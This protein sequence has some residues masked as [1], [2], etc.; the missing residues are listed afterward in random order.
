M[1]AGPRVSRGGSMRARWCVG[2]LAVLG[3][4][5]EAW[6]QSVELPSVLVTAEPEPPKNKA[7]KKTKKSTGEKG[8]VAP[9]PG[10]F[11][12]TVDGAKTDDE[13][14]RVEQANPQVIIDRERF[15]AHPSGPRAN[16]AIKRLPGV[17]VSGGID[18]AKDIRIRGLDKEFSRVA[19]DGVQLP[20]SGE[21]R[22]LQINRVPS[23]A[24]ESLTLVRT[25]TADLEHDGIA[26]R[27]EI[28][29]RDIPKV[30]TTETDAAVG[31]IDGV[32]DFAGHFQA[33]TGGRVGNVGLMVYGSVVEEPR[34]KSKDKFNA[35][36]LKTE[37]EY[38]TKPLSY[39]NFGGDLA[40]F[41]GEGELHLKP[42]VAMQTEDKEKTKDKFSNGAFNGAETEEEAADKNTYGLTLSNTHKV[43]PGAL[44]ESSVGYYET[45]EVKDKVKH[46][47]KKDGTENLSGLT[48]TE[49]DKTDAF[50][51]AKL[52]YSQA[53]DAAGDVRLK[54]GMDSRFRTRDKGKHETVNGVLSNA[55]GK[56]VY[57]LDET[58]L[59]PYV[60]SDIRFGDLLV[61]PGL[62]Y[63]QVY[64]ES[65]DGSGNIGDFSIGDPLPSLSARYTLTRE[66]YVRAGYARTVTRPKFDELTPFEQED[67]NKITIGNPNLRPSYAHGVDA[68]FEYA[69]PALF[70]G[71]NVFRR[72]ITDLIESVTIGTKNGKDVEQVQNTGD[73]WIQGLELEQRVNFGEL[74]LTALNGLVVTANETFIQ[75]EVQPTT[76]GAVA[77]RFKDQPKFVGNLIVEYRLPVWQTLFG[78]AFNYTGELKQ[79]ASG[80]GDDKNAQLIVDAQIT[81]PVAP[82]VSLYL[83]GQNLTGE[84]LIKNKSNGE[85][86]V[87]TSSRTFL[88]G[89]RSR[90]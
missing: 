38:E 44:L 70:L 21:K 58:Y 79:V 23:F 81:Q 19:V 64:S 62:R 39:K 36:G 37:S 18:E 34:E 41:Y 71:Q 78:V 51:Q 26:G 45:T 15:A 68:G 50:W 66:L 20:D 10:Y 55:K 60:R 53:L 89:M 2:L 46:V 17:V 25:P 24:V 35:A 12:T 57:S 86:E 75:S 82:G 87:E 31:R 88:V 29:T 11:V 83:S 43:A 54:I 84:T 74:G 33:L 16:D 56:D 61:T 22:E 8:V 52:A 1:F 6:A 32:G 47:I 5:C 49:E 76:P 65:R 40:W 30:W 77:R 80:A 48:L 4:P 42:F 67:S 27:L 85:T 90:F 63:E 9:S 3:V 69:S 72:D 14:R 73:G 13:Y 59:A 7:N 28:K